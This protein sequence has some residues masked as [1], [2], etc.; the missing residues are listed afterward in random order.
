M[1]HRCSETI[2][3]SG[4]Q[5]GARQRHPYSRQAEIGTTGASWD[6]GQT[7]GAARCGRTAR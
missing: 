2:S 1:N 7:P 4:V 5:R 3:G 6:D